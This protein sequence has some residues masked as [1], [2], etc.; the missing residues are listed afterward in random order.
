MLIQ[1]VVAAAPAD[2]PR[3]DE[4]Q[5]DPTVALFALGLSLVS[6]MIFGGRAGV[7]RLATRPVGWFETGWLEG[8]G[9]ESQ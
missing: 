6:T 8:N 5:M 3:I 7:A 9:L 1:G 2:L 4:V